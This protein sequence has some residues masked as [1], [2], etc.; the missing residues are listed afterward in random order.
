MITAKYYTPKE[1][2]IWTPFPFEFDKENIT[3]FLRKPG[4]ETNFNVPMIME[5]ENTEPFE[6]YSI[7]FSDGSIYDSGIKCYF[8]S[9]DM[10]PK[11]ETIKYMETILDT[12]YP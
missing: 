2:G 5:N 8:R 9:E 7:L 3:P 6:A 12:K 4:Q 10:F 11:D 1:G